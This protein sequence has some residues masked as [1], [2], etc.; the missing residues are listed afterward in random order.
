M[1]VRVANDVDVL[2]AKT[3]Q[4]ACCEEVYHFVCA[5]ITRVPKK[6]LVDV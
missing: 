4:C 1:W 6:S 5:G 2:E 3:I